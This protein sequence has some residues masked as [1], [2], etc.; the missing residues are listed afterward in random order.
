[1][2]QNFL[3]ENAPARI[4][5]AMS[6]FS[7]TALVLHA[8][9]NMTVVDENARYFTLEYVDAFEAR[10]AIE[11]AAGKV[12][13]YFPPQSQEPNYVAFLATEIFIEMMKLMNGAEGLIAVR[14]SDRH[15]ND[16]PWLRQEFTVNS[17][18]AIAKAG[19][20]LVIRSPQ[21]WAS[22]LHGARHV[23]FC[24]LDDDYIFTLV[25]NKTHFNF[26]PRSSEIHVTRLRHELLHFDDSHVPLISRRFDPVE[27]AR[28]AGDFL[29]LDD[30]YGHIYFNNI[31][32][33]PFGRVGY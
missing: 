8:K 15:P 24:V 26:Y 20:R 11:R 28:V 6:A 13:Y 1:M 31:P 25:Q 21:E 12:E 9:E 10:K 18:N 2:K 17:T 4:C 33:A 29:L 32:G 3:N 22:E 19:F 7:W 23:E 5:W 16:R 14:L 27:I 30:Y